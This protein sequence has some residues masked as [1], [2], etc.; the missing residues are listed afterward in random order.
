MTTRLTDAALL[1]EIERGSSGWGVRNWPHAVE[2]A[3]LMTERARSLW[4]PVDYGTSRSPRYSIIPAPVVGSPVSYGFNGD[5]YPC[6]TIVKV[7]DATK[8]AKR[9]ETSDGSVFY[10]RK[11]SASWIKAGGTWCMVVG[12][13]D[14]RN[15]SF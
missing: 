7:S 6:G 1:D 4:L 2:L 13:R 14:E 11:L 10:R 15:P 8:G 9:V 12:H 5:Y 3:A